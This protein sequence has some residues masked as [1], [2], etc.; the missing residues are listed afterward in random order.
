MIC[1]QKK[2]AIFTGCLPA[3][4][5]RKIMSSVFR[6]S[7]SNFTRD[8]A[9]GGAVRHLLKKGISID[10]ILRDYDYPY[11]REELVRMKER[12]ENA[13]KQDK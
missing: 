8:F 11:G 2:R 13:Q 6:E 10:R 5:R 3:A 1:V 12:L 9:Y 7:L 4:E